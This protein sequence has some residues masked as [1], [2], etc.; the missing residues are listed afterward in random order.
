MAQTE[1]QSPDHMAQSELLTYILKSSE[2][3]KIRMEDI[4]TMSKSRKIVIRWFE[5]E[6]DS[7]KLH[8]IELKQS[9]MALTPV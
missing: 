8:S 4:V 5:C 9:N 2:I 1:T 6:S 3:K 7:H